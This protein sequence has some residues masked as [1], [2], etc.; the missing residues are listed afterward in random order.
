MSAVFGGVGAA[1]VAAN[2][3][4]NILFANNVATG[5]TGGFILETNATNGLGLVELKNNSII[6]IITGGTQ[7]ELGVS[8]QSANGTID[9]LVLT[10]NSFLDTAG[11]PSMQYGVYLASGTIGLLHV[12]QNFYKGATVANYLENGLTV[13]ARQGFQTT[14]NATA[15]VA[16]GGTVTHGLG[17]TPT[18]VL[19]MATTTGEFVSVTAKSSTTFTVAIKKHDNSAGTT[20]TLYWAAIV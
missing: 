16:D 13:T 3:T 19:V 15:S 17:T 1:T 14:W 12:A 10:G 18:A 20:Q 6:D 11:S 7:T 8:Y 5:F 2:K 9:E 4:K